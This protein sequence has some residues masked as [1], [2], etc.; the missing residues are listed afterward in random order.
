MM[1]TTTE[2]DLDISDLEEE[3]E[4][5]GDE[6]DS[7]FE[8][9]STQLPDMWHETDQ[10]MD[11]QSDDTFYGLHG[12]NPKYLPDRREIELKE[13]FFTDLC[14]PDSLFQDLVDWTN[15]R[16]RLYL[17]ETEMTSKSRCKSWTDVTL[18]GMKKTFA[19]ILLM[20]IVKKQ[21][22]ASYWSTAEL[23]YTNFFFDERCLSRDRFINIMKFLRFADYENLTGGALKKIR[24]FIGELALRFYDRYNMSNQVHLYFRKCENDF[25]GSLPTFEKCCSG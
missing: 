9:A 25:K 13:T 20:G 12:L 2:V 17:A 14:L 18:D 3:V 7:D 23:L 19:C 8:D 6:T 5:S 10:S 22:I 11:H 4:F 1:A 16:A 21:T 24:P 15:T